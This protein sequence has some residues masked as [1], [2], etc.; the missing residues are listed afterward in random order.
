MVVAGEAHRLPRSAVCLTEAAQDEA[1]RAAEVLEE[2]HG[3]AVRRTA[4]A[5]AA[6][7]LET[8]RQRVEVGHSVMISNPGLAAVP[9]VVVLAVAVPAVAVAA[10]AA[11][12][13]PLQGEV[14]EQ[15]VQQEALVRLLQ[16]RSGRQYP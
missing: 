11:A 7:H 4:V 14:A 5:E 15:Q 12:P 1:V 13:S 10:V 9:A 6:H 2:D 3:V 8:R 16:R